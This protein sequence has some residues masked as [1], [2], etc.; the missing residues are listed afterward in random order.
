MSSR[1]VADPC[2]QEAGFAQV[3]SF[4]LFGLYPLATT[5]PVEGIPEAGLT[6]KDICHTV[7]APV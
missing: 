2:G 3:I 1:P 5:L 7:S 4:Q 6:E